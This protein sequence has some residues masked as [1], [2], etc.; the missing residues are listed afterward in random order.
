MGV[1]GGM[2]AQAT[3]DFEARVHR[4]AQRL[5]PQDWNHGYPPMVVWYH[6]GLPILRGDDGRPLEPRRV[7]PELVDAAAKLGPLVDFLVVPCNAAHIGL[8]ELRDAAGCPVVSMID[9][10]IDEVVR[11]R[12]RRVGVLGAYGAPPP[13]LEALRGRDIA[14][15]AIDGTRQGRLDAGIQAVMEGGD[16]KE[17]TDAARAAVGDVRAR[18]VDAVILGCTEIPLLLRDEGDAADLINPVALLAEVAVRLA[19]GPPEA[20]GTSSQAL[21]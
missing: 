15:E 4:C 9:V 7:D 14:C 3:M 12:C 11:R 19:I 6:R 1:L 2:S 13:Y 8:R 18:G 21:P 20:S 16:G 17:H 5:I 10:A